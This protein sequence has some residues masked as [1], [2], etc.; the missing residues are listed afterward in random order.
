MEWESFFDRP[1]NSDQYF[2]Q[3]R[4]IMKNKIDFEMALYRDRYIKGRIYHRIRAKNISSVKD[5]VEYLKNNPQELQNLKALLTIHT[6]E[7]FR[8]INPFRY[9]E[10][11]ILPRLARSANNSGHRIKILSAPCSTGQEVYSIAIIVH[12]LIKSGVI[13]CPV[14]IIGLD[15]DKPSIQKARNGIYRS[16]EMKNISEQIMKDY[17]IK[18]DSNYRIKDELK[19]F[20]QFEVHDLFKTLP[21][22][23][24]FDLILCRN[25]L[26]YISYEDQ[27]QI[28]ENLNTHLK[29]GGYIMLG[30]TEGFKLMNELDYEIENIDER[31][32]KFK[33][34]GK[35]S[36]LVDYFDNRTEPEITQDSSRIVY[37]SP[38]PIE[39]RSAVP[40]RNLPAATKRLEAATNRLSKKFNPIEQPSIKVPAQNLA[41]SGPSSSIKNETSV[42][43]SDD[44]YNQGNKI[45]DEMK[46]E[47]TPLSVE[48]IDPISREK[49][50]NSHA[51]ITVLSEEELKAQM[52]VILTKEK[53]ISKGG[54]K[55]RVSNA[56]LESDSE[57]IEKKAV[58]PAKIN[59]KL[60]KST[61]K[62]MISGSFDVS[63][64]ESK[65]KKKHLS[66]EQALLAKI[67]E[68][69][70][71][72]YREIQKIIQ[73]I[74]PEISKDSESHETQDIPSKGGK[75]KKKGSKVKKSVEKK[76]EKE[77][78]ELPLS[79]EEVRKRDISMDF[80]LKKQDEEREYI[81]KLI[82]IA[83]KNKS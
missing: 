80:I 62:V 67:E 25:F 71:E 9:L 24:K 75:K 54:V 53:E 1:E 66:E 31:I 39:K 32:Y 34:K 63:K 83:K 17:F 56:N 7:F 30:I 15:I 45:S 11:T 70:N 21:F 27:M 35:T 51:K 69:K 46:S 14:E 81:Q 29:R 23:S 38:D 43:H 10:T 48:T 55:V 61:A 36:N 49:I 82:E 12:Q 79:P 64:V 40:K 68:I 20:C 41:S 5:Y 73:S 26:I 59:K 65:D 76:I 37:V 33:G 16:D 3:I 77:E 52:E 18:S 47:I 2:N 13:K 50:E 42:K 72:K 22:D 4:E 44:I 58:E 19:Q 8:D 78:P 6:T 60:K 74:K 57:I 28:I